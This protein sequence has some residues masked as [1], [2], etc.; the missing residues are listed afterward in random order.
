MKTEFE[1]VTE[2]YATKITMI[3]VVLFFLGLGLFHY[4]MCSL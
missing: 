2:K 1:K 4:L 3:D